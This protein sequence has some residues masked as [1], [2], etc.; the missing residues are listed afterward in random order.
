MKLSLNQLLSCFIMA[1]F[2]LSSRFNDAAYSKKK[3]IR[4]K[5]ITFNI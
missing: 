4:M 2:I 5:F 1:I 3:K